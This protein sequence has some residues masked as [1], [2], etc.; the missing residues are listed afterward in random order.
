M[1]DDPLSAA[2]GIALGCLLGVAIWIVGLA[3]VFWRW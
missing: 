3:I 1:N 2:R